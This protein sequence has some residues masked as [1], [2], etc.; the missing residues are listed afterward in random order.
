MED[1]RRFSDAFTRNREPILA[2]LAPHVRPGDRAVELGAGSGQL[3]PFIKSLKSI[4]T[5][6][7][8]CT[9]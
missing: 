8:I 1:A 5:L 4:I 9:V 7:N 2:A 6:K 3:I